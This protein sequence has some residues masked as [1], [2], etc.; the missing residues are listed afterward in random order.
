MDLQLGLV[1]DFKIST[2]L[3]KFIVKHLDMPHAQNY[4]PALFLANR[5]GGVVWSHRNSRHNAEVDNAH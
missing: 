1:C 5:G 4:V 3:E 2:R